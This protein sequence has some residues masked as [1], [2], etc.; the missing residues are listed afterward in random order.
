MEVTN[1]ADPAQDISGYTGDAGLLPGMLEVN[2][3]NA[4]E[5]DLALEE[6]IAVI[7]ETAMEHRTGVLVTRIGAG[8]YIVRAHPGVP[9]GLVRQQYV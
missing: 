1:L 4:A 7:T 2:V 6:A 3:S 9:Y 8:S 5:V